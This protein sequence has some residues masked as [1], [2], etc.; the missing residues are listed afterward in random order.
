MA[1]NEQR[2]IGHNKRMCTFSANML[3][4]TTNK[5]TVKKKTT[6][7]KRKTNKKTCKQ[8]NKGKRLICMY[9]INLVTVG[10]SLLRILLDSKLCLLYRYMP[11]SPYCSLYFHSWL[12]YS[13][14]TR[15]AKPQT[16]PLYHYHS[17]CSCSR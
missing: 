16:R 14:F 12:P 8:W 13:M 11:A 6:T 3:F 15:Y 1:K 4:H 10:F 7:K 5:Q 2:L 17:Y 9:C